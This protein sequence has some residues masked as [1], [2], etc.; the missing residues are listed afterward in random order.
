MIPSAS[1][2]EFLTIQAS[3]RPGSTLYVVKTMP[4]PFPRIPD[5]TRRLNLVTLQGTFGTPIRGGLGLETGLSGARRRLS[6]ERGH[7][8][9]FA[10]R[11]Q[12]GGV[13]IV[14]LE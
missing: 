11:R 10:G 13:V 2:L 14:L 5:V 12:A 1:Q 6:G 7:G 4:T 8:A 9:A 3:S